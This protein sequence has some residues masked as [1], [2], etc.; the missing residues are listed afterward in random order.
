[1]FGQISA[2]VHTSII[3]RGIE[4]SSINKIVLNAAFLRLSTRHQIVLGLLSN[5]L[6]QQNVADIVGMSRT[7]VGTDKKAATAL[8]QGYINDCRSHGEN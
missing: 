1:M 5:G 3:Q 6:T 2:S 4:E 7:S 8:L